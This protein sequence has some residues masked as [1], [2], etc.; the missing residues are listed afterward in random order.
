MP[1]RHFSYDPSSCPEPQAQGQWCS[2]DQQEQKNP[3]MEPSHAAPLPPLHSSLSSFNNWTFASPISHSHPPNSLQISSPPT[4]TDHRVWQVTACGE[5]CRGRGERS[6]MFLS[7]WYLTKS[8]GPEVASNI[9]LC[10]S[11]SPIPSHSVSIHGATAVVGS[12][13]CLF[14]SFALLSPLPVSSHGGVSI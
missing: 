4:F 8:S 9:G 5:G 7:C 2:S 13:F 14:A 10:S 11:C 1:D 12:L 3:E 6:V